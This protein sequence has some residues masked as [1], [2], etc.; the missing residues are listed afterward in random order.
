VGAARE[1]DDLKSHRASHTPEAV[2]DRLAGGPPHSYLRD[3]IYGAI[4]GAVTTFA[5]VAGVAGAQLSTGVIVVLGLANLLADGFSMAVGNFLGTRAE[6]QVR[7]RLRQVE[8]DHIARYPDGEREEIRQIFEAKGFRGEDL[9]R[10]VDVITADRERWI[11]VM[12]TDEHGVAPTAPNPLRAALSTFV[13]FVVAGSLPLSVFVV[14]LFAPA[15]TGR[16]FLTSVVLTSLTFFLVGTMKSRFVL[17]RWWVA[18][19]ETML[20]GG[21]AA[22]LAYGV[23]SLLRG[24]VDAL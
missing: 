12:L 4:D 10:V 1:G 20:M 19:L 22:G 14:E 15:V 6:G 8:E 24:L 5:I 11:D 16:P 23:G 21:A 18:G 7:Q 17:Q 9:E 2:R 3:F 13:A